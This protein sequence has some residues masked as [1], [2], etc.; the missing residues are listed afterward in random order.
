MT[1]YLTSEL[2]LDFCFFFNMTKYLASKLILDSCFLRIKNKNEYN[3]APFR[4]GSRYY[5]SHK[6][7][8]ALDT[9]VDKLHTIKNPPFRA[10]N[11]HL[12]AAGVEKVGLSRS[13]FTIMSKKFD[14]SGFFSVVEITCFI[15]K[16]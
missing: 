4:D 5:R 14:H 12:R 2:I 11:R 3:S 6:E 1:K 15:W 13:L 16:P 7:N 8:M 10:D 9:F